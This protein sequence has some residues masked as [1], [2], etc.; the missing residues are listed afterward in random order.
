MS[1]DLATDGQVQSGGLEQQPQRNDNEEM[2][3]PKW[4]S[5]FQVSQRFTTPGVVIAGARGFTGILKAGRP[6]GNPVFLAEE[7]PIFLRLLVVGSATCAR[8]DRFPVPTRLVQQRAS[9][10]DRAHP[11][12]RL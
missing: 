2:A 3:L 1:C 4:P 12:L 9:E 8:L 5:K 10:P 7:G 11:S 6:Q